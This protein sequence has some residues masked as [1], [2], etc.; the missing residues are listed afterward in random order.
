VASYIGI[1]ETVIH[2][3]I[4]E[5][6]KSWLATHKSRASKTDDTKTFRDFIEFMAAGSFSKTIASTLAYPHGKN[7]IRILIFTTLSLYCFLLLVF[8]DLLLT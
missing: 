4:Y 5:A 1:S 7:H 6:V 8:N 3:V 2:F